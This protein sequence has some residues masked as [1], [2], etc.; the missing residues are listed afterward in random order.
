MAIVV[1]FLLSVAV[2]PRSAGAAIQIPDVT[3]Q[4]VYA[5]DLETG[6]KLFARNEHE[7]MP[8]GSTVKVVTALVTVKYA[9]LDD[10]VTV[11]ESDLMDNPAYSN[12]ALQAGDT[13]TVS[14][15][16]YGLLVP[17]GSDGANALARHVGGI[18]SGSDDQIA[19]LDAFVAEMNA[20][21]AELGLENSRFSNP[22]GID[23]P[24][25]YSSAYDIAILSGLLMENEFLAS[26]VGEPGYSFTSVGPEARNY[27]AATTNQLI[28]QSGVVGIKTG[29]TEEAGGCVVLARQVNGGN[30]MV[31]TAVIGSDLTYDDAGAIV[32]DQ[33]WTDATALFGYM[34][35]T[36]AWLP[37]NDVN[38]FVNLPT[39]LQ[40]WDVQVAGNPW[41]PVTT[42]DT[43][44]QYQLALSPEG[45]GT[46]DIYYDQDRVGSLPLEPAGAAWSGMAAA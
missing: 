44:T 31:I 12:M 35:A 40:V 45:G 21:V 38:T 33:R 1:A 6:I 8:I 43:M 9:D 39:E 46:I 17:S 24:N 25:T 27:Q 41:I 29:S 37:L 10:E 30:S 13:L 26:V 19:Q 32:D 36:F 3:A 4:G 7:R 34:D 28:G 42:D 18:I 2:P 11:I 20:F 23:A 15:L 5:Y 14:Q 22:H 16:L